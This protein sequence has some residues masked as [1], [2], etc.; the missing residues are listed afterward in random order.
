MITP[1]LDQPD[2]ASACSVLP[3]GRVDQA[4]PDVRVAVAVFVDLFFIGEFDGRQPT[5]HRRCAAAT[6]KAH[7]TPVASGDACGR[8][9]STKSREFRST[10][11]RL[12]YR[13]DLRL[14]SDVK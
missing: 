2:R 12:D 9:S 10:S 11:G 7:L 4:E 5:R 3:A 13:L 8:S 6:Q 14:T 1:L